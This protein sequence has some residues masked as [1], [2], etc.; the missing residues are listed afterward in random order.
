MFMYYWKHNLVNWKDRF[1][2]KNIDKI[3]LNEEDGDTGRD[4]FGQKGRFWAAIIS[5]VLLLVSGIVIWRP[6]FAGAFAIPLIRLALVV[7]S[8]S[9]AALLIV[10]MV[11]IY[12]ALWV[13]GTLTAM[14]EGWVSLNWARQQHPRGYRKQRNRPKKQEIRP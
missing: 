7:H 6:C 5:L 1:W 14:A 3:A 4:N 12:A 11:H 8:V 2:A 9:A 10:I 13:K